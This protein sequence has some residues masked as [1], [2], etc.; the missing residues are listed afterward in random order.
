MKAWSPNHYATR[1]PT[2][3]FSISF[4]LACLFFFFH[5]KKL[6]AFQVVWSGKIPAWKRRHETRIQSLSAEDPLKEDMATHSS[7]LAWSIPW[8]EKPGRLQPMES[9]RVRHNWS[10]LACT[11][12]HLTGDLPLSK[13]SSFFKFSCCILTVDLPFS[14]FSSFFKFSCCI[15][16]VGFILHRT[17]LYNLFT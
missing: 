8:T 1:E 12:E 2:F 5:G 9:Q 13:F 15:L 16:T 11:Q 3:C 6:G 4:F 14:K 7:I 10:D 17:D